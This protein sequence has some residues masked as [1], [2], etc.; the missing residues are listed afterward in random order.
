MRVALVQL[1]SRRDVDKNLDT[2]RRLAEEAAEAGAKWILFPENAPFLGRDADKIPIAESIDG[3]MVSAF[4][5]MARQFNAWITLGSFPESSPD[6][7]R[8]YNTQVLLGP[9]G[10]IVNHY[11]KI[12]LFDVQIDDDVNFCESDSVYPGEEVVDTVVTDPDG[13]DRCVGMTICYDLRFPEIY[14]ALQTRG[15]DAITIPSAFTLS[16][17][18]VHWHALLKARA[19]ENQAYILAPNQWGHH[20]GKRRSYGQS[21]I[22]DP[23]GRCVACA[24]DRESIIVA[25]L[26]FDYLAEIRR[27]MPVLAHRRDDLTI[28]TAGD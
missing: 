19:I 27:A 25:E 3:P 21:A 26:D 18:S 17:G 24:S 23:W 10:S 7:K 1:T 15:V 16:T 22:Y 9:D 12:H 8:T 6:P 5:E 14:R 28:D 4:A 13:Q 2:C 11:R 20:F